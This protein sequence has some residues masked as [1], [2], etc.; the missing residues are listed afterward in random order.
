VLERRRS[1][2]ALSPIP[3]RRLVNLISYALAPR[4]VNAEGRVRSLSLSSGALHAVE[5]VLLARGEVYRFD[6]RRRFLQT[7]NLSDPNKLGRFY[8]RTR[9]ILPQANAAAMVLIGDLPRIRAFYAH[10]GSLLFRDSGALLQTLALACE[11]YG[12]GFCPLGL[13]GRDVVE[14]IGL[15]PK[16]AVPLGAAALGHRASTN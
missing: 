16:V 11:A 1:Q 14:A 6:I 15:D 4:F 3:F 12:L 13:L 2:R 10:P 5:V 9:D 8:T 7:L